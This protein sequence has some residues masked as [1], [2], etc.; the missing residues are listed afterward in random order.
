MEKYCG[1]DDAISIDR[2]IIELKGNQ[3]IKSWMSSNSGHI[4]PL[5]LELPALERRKEC[6][7][8]DSTFI[9]D[10]IIIKLAGN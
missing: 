7:G 4:H 6:C 3:G 10:R 5:T 8:Y 1:H 2:I 9:F